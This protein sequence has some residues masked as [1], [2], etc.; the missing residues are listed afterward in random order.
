MFRVFALALMLMPAAAQ[1]QKFVSV[2][3]EILGAPVASTFASAPPAGAD[4]PTDAGP[5][6]TTLDPASLGPDT[7]FD[8]ASI[9]EIRALLAQAD[10]N[11]VAADVRNSIVSGVATDEAGNPI[12]TL[13]VAGSV[14]GFG[15]ETETASNPELGECNEGSAWVSVEVNCLNAYPVEDD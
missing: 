11:A 12:L 9:E 15:T 4:T 3:E 6:G 13:D 14:P 5:E 7:I 1:A 2:G 8:G 10:A